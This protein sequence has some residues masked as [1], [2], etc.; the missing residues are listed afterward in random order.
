MMRSIA[1]VAIIPSVLLLAGGLMAQREDNLSLTVVYDNVSLEEELT[2][3]WGFSC[4]IAGAEKRIL[5]DAG[6]KGSILLANMNK[7]SIAPGSIDIIF[8][9]HEH[10]DHA[11]GLWDFLEHNAQITLFIP[12]SFSLDFK[13]RARGYGISLVEV[14][15]QTEICRGV[16]ST[17]QLGSS[18][19][20][21]AL[22]MRTTDGLVVITGC[23]HP[24]I[25]E[26]LRSAGKVSR[27]KVH[28]V[29]GGFHLL[30]HSPEEVKAIIGQFKNIGVE[31]V[32][33]C[34]CTGEKAMELFASEYGANYIAIGA[35]KK[36]VLGGVV[37][38]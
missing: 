32:G 7:L 30:N 25:V 11:G 16:Y 2:P 37:S 15:G 33:A 29:L 5:F 20:E 8:I 34:H 36:L 19:K 1:V 6:T 17:G 26:I 22:V 27:E 24:G 38:E 35:G 12:A 28:M 21:Q 9:S 3:D 31:K 10:R 14:E 4:V 13:N 23:A 18:T